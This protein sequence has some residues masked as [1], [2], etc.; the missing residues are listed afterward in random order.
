MSLDGGFS[1][2]LSGVS[3][4]FV[5]GKVGA[6]RWRGDTAGH[7]GMRALLWGQSG[8][9]PSELCIGLY[10]HATEMESD[11]SFRRLGSTQH[12]GDVNDIAFVDGSL[13]LTASSSGSVFLYQLQNNP[14]MQPPDNESQ[15]VDP[16]SFKPVSRA[17]LH[18]GAATSIDAQSLSSDVVSAGQDGCLHILAITPSDLR[19]QRSIDR[20]STSSIYHARFTGVH[21]FASCGMGGRLCLWDMR[22]DSNRPSNTLLK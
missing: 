6:A 10:Q 22:S 13:V 18:A 16:M 3:R 1:V 9:K 11:S 14:A 21:S 8:R 7:D 15:S 5:E 2:V 20:A 19:S 12:E 17:R 4:V